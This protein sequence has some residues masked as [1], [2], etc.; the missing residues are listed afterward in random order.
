MYSNVETNMTSYNEVRQMASAVGYDQ[1]T[2]DATYEFGDPDRYIVT[3][4]ICW[5][6]VIFVS[7]LHNIPGIISQGPTG[8]FSENFLMS[9]LPW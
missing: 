8:Y 2:C 9:T 3:Y 4:L 7:R 5:Y 6:I 1:T